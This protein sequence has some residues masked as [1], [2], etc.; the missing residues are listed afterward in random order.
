M[1]FL[2]ISVFDDLLLSTQ[3]H[4]IH[5]P[6]S[7]GPNNKYLVAPC[8]AM[9]GDASSCQMG[10][11]H[12]NECGSDCKWMQA[13]CELEDP[14]KERVIRSIPCSHQVQGVAVIFGHT[15]TWFHQCTPSLYPSHHTGWG[16]SLIPLPDSHSVSLFLS[17]H[18]VTTTAVHCGRIW[19]EYYRSNECY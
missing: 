19:G 2:Q 7:P 16:S 14:T 15:T 10:Q 3:L 13:R 18:I 8:T 17:A 5:L 11:T 1:A 4:A 9:S 6:H 12:P